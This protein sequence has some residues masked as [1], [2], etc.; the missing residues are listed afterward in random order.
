MKWNLINDYTPYTN[1]LEQTLKNRNLDYNY[2][3]LTEDVLIDPL[4][5]DNIKLASEILLKHCQNQHE[6]LIIVDSDCDGY[7]SAATLYNYLIIAFPNMINNIDIILHDTKIHGIPIERIPL[8]KYELI[9]V[10]DAGTNDIEQQQT[11]LET[12]TDLIIL[13]HH[14]AEYEFQCNEH[15]ALVNNQISNNY[16]NKM[17]SG[18]GIV[19]K[20]LNILDQTLN[21]EF[22]P[23]F[24]D[25]VA[26]GL[27]ADMQSVQ[28]PETAYLIRE[29]LKKENIHNPF[30]ITLIQNSSFTIDINNMNYTTVSFY[31]AP[32]INAVTR[33]GTMEEK[34]LIFSSMLFNYAY[35]MILSTKR[36]YTDQLETLV[37][38][39][40]RTCINIKNRQKKLKDIGA[41][42]IKS[43]LNNYDSNNKAIILNINNELDKGLIGLVANE[44]AGEFHKPVALVNPNDEELLGSMRGY[45]KSELKDFKTILESCSEVN[46]VRGHLNSAGVSIKHQQIPELIK[47][48]NQKLNNI[49]FSN[50][51]NIDYIIDPHYDTDWIKQQIITLDRVKYIWGRGCEEPLLLFENFPISN[52]DINLLRRGTLKIN[53]NGISAIKFFVKDSEYEQ[54]IECDNKNINI[55]GYA[56]INNWNGIIQP[57]IK[58]VDY[59]I[60]NKKFVY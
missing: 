40:Y 51:Y 15:F 36:G 31:I 19:W 30:L 27:A 21:I 9:I 35:K 26:V 43:L 12:N 59:Q 29:G 45:D 16:S 20:L 32:F 54:L 49:D 34:T 55:I 33:V 44:I 17:L 8:T 42:Y 5:L 25:L 11:L 7:T 1:I 18:V 4:L 38:Q 22:A 47:D 10:P 46:W 3:N 2:L 41:N 58:I 39:A 57:Q 50:N 28:Y 52:N 13:D 6:I 14:E 23:I 56:T 53:L 37:E 60:V 48:L 24:L